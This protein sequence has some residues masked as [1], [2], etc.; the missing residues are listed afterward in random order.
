MKNKL[1]N[2]VKKYSIY[3]VYFFIVIFLIGIFQ[4]LVEDLSV[5]IFNK[6]FN[7]SYEQK[8]YN[9]LYKGDVSSEKCK[10]LFEEK[11]TYSYYL[12]N[13][14]SNDYVYSYKNK[15]CIFYKYTVRKNYL[16][17]NYVHEYYLIDPFSNNILVESFSIMDRISFIDYLNNKKYEYIYNET[18]K[19]NIPSFEWYKFKDLVK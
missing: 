5:N 12:D 1:F 4:Y 2:S 19:Y 7:K 6:I 14:E 10:N 13:I 15:L 9:S 18:K 11:N 17:D 8:V 16:N 3:I